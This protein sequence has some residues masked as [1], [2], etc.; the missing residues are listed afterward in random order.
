MISTGDKFR[1]AKDILAISTAYI[2]SRSCTISW[3][4][5]H[6][7]YSLMVIS[8]PHPEHKYRRRADISHSCLMAC[9]LVSPITSFSSR[10]RISPNP[11]QEET[12]RPHSVPLPLSPPPNA[13]TCLSHPSFGV[14]FCRTFPSVTAPNLT[15]LGEQ[16]NIHSVWKTLWWQWFILYDD[17]TKL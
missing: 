11:S 9:P 4:P 7:S 3:P 12:D 8:I 17:S 5:A 16:C 2:I 1:T 6:I 10:R 15:K 13:N 14:G